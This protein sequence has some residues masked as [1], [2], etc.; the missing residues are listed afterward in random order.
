MTTPNILKDTTPIPDGSDPTLVRSVITDAWGLYFAQGGVVMAAALRAMDLVLARDDLRLASASAVF[1]RP[2]ACGPVETRVQV[3]RS[4]RRG[5]Q[6]HG[7]L[8]DQTAPEDAVSVAV[9]AVFTDPTIEGPELAPL[10]CPPELREVPADETAAS[11]IPDNDFPLGFLDNTEWHVAVRPEA[12]PQR[13]TQPAPEVLPRLAM[14]FRFTDPPAAP[15]ESWQPALLPI[16]GD[17]LGSALVVALG[18]GTRP[19]GSVSLQMDLQVHAPISG[20][21]IGIDSTCTH[22]GNGLASGVLQLWSDA[23]VHVATVSQTAML[24]SLT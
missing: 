23:G 10:V 11:S 3:L 4:G 7:A 8:R 22:I 19:V 18:G 6:V 1:C 5:A 13:T 17:A 20:S 21:W 15:G 24:R 16:P 14:W 2:V 9:N 12:E